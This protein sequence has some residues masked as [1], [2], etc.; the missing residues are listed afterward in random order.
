MTVKAPDG[1]FWAWM[2]LLAC[3]MGNLIGDG[4]MYRFALNIN[5]KQK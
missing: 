5:K 1:G 4:V 2:A 3:F